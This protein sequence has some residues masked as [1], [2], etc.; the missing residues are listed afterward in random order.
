MCIGMNRKRASWTSRTITALA[1]LAGVAG[2]G[3]GLEPRSALASETFAVG[4][5]GGPGSSAEPQTELRDEDGKLLKVVPLGEQRIMNALPDLE[6]KPIAPLPADAPLF[7]SQSLVAEVEPNGTPATATPI[8]ANAVGTGSVFPTGDVDVWSLAVTGGDRVYVATGGGADT[9]SFGETLLELVDS[10][11]VTILESDDD[12]GIQMPLSSTIA[13]KVIPGSGAKT[14]YIRVRGSGAFPSSQVRPYQLHVRVQSGSPVPET[15]ENN[16]AAIQT[17]PAS[18]WVSG[19]QNSAAD[20]Q[21]NWGITLS[22]GDTVYL[23]ADW[24]PERDGTTHDGVISFGPFGDAPGSLVGLNDTSTTSPN[25]DAVFWTV[26]NAGTYQIAISSATAF[27][28]TAPHTYM[29]SVSVHPA[30]VEGA[31][32]TT[33][34]SGPI[35]VPIGPAA[36]NFST[37]IT[38]IITV[39]GPGPRRIADLNV[40]IQ[41]DHGLMADIDAH[42]I[43][44]AG[45]NNGLFT[46][47]GET[48]AGGQ[49]GMDLTLDDEA[50]SSI[51]Q[52]KT[53]IGLQLTPEMDYRLS[54]FD[55]ENAVGN[56]TLALWDDAASNGGT[57]TGWSLTICEPPPPP[58]CAGTLATVYSSNFES[59]NGGFTVSP[60]SPTDWAYGTGSSPCNSGSKCWKT[61]ATGFY[62]QLRN[63]DLLSPSISLAGLTAPITATWAQRYAMRTASDDAYSVEVRNVPTANTRELFRFMDFT[64]RDTVSSGSFNVDESA[65]WGLFSRDISSYAGTTVQLRYNLTS[66][67]TTPKLAGPSIDD[68]TVTGCCT[69][70]SCS[71]GVCSPFGCC[72]P[73]SCNDGNSCTTDTCDAVNGC[74]HTTLKD[75]APC[76]D[77]NVCTV[78]DACSAGVCLGNLPPTVSYCSTGSTTIPSGPGASTPYPSPISVAGGSVVCKVRVTLDGVFHT[79]PDDIDMLLSGPGGQNAKIMS[80]VGGTADLGGLSLAIDDSASSSMPDGGPLFA[81]GKDAT[82]GGGTY[83]PTDINDGVDTFPAPAPAPAGG[84]ALSVFNGSNP[85]GTWNLWIVDDRAGDSGSL[86]RW[87]VQISYACTADAQCPS[88]GEPC[89]DD[90]C[91]SGACAHVENHNACDDGNPCTANDV[92]GSGFCDGTPIVTPGEAQGLRLLADKQTISWSATPGSTSYDVV[93]GAVAALPVGPFA[94]DEICFPDNVGTSVVDA[95][96]PALGTS[97]WYLVRA[98][99][100]AGNGIYGFQSNGTPQFTFTCP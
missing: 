29:L 6:R 15:A 83:K 39:P 52:V 74:V 7:A 33:Y 17:L 91:V 50:A 62:S 97:N 13:G 38:S 10:D 82:F 21:D 59:N 93:R 24:D 1:L 34:S 94:G 70:A 18:G 55:G 72:T 51:V 53:L 84:S 47:I 36:T 12:D 73:A 65:G 56:W 64:M 11:G 4:S 46:D 85:N 61:G 48:V 31:N 95:T 26:K 45:N 63:E 76:N 78:N 100:C 58:A 42:L 32:C 49:H 80:D 57:L 87:C 28:P 60:A 98:E 3:G 23:S 92:C 69:A 30:T 44:P 16:D 54:W 66:N 99:N 71:G 5:D 81:E 43:S 96:L 14:V 20:L 25:S 77:G 35:S 90:V 27:S 37:P 75:G 40:S 86:N 89:T 79:N 22:A 9:A 2:L 41:L 8:G 67:I 19:A 68:V 88:D